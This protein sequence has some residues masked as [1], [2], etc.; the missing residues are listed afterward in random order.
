VGGAV[1][2]QFIFERMAAHLRVS[3]WGGFVCGMGERVF[4]GG[5]EGAAEAVEPNEAA[6]GAGGEDKGAQDNEVFGQGFDLVTCL[7]GAAHEAAQAADIRIE[8][9]PVKV[10]VPQVAV[11]KVGGV[12]AMFVGVAVAGLAAALAF[13]R[14]GRLGHIP[15]CALLVDDGRA[16]ARRELDIPILLL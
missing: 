12:E 15:R 1:I 6:E 8:A 16:R 14:G 11:G 13:G 7:A 4:G 5:A 9:E 10:E 2:F 3:Q